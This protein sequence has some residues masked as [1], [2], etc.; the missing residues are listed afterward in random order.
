MRTSHRIVEHL[1]K[2][3]I[4]YFDGCPNHQPT[5]DLVRDVVAA[6]ELDA[7]IVETEVTSP[8]DAGRLRFLGSPSVRVDGVD[9]EPDARQRRDF[10][11]SCRTYG[12][13]GMPD[14]EMLTRALREAQAGDV[15]DGQAPGQRAGLL[16]A[17]GAV[18]SALASSACC[19]VPLVLIGFGVS[20]GG[21]SG[22]MEKYRLLF[23]G[24]AAVMLATGFYFV[25][26]RATVCAAGCGCAA[27]RSRLRQFNRVMIW[28]ATALVIATA[29]FPKTIGYL[30]GDTATAET[31]VPASGVITVTFAVE[32]MTCDGCAVVLRTSLVKVPGV[33]DARVSYPDRQAVIS[34]DSA[35]LSGNELLVAAIRSAGYDVAGDADDQP[36]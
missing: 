7:E 36:E 30:L 6:A 4:L 16:A 3:E 22:W 5:V 9:V 11:L 34:I 27:P 14:R 13:R 17:G 24:A 32:G 20:A 8:D 31:A 26:F 15:P 33:L 18:A 19:W 35:V 10:G 12:G 29:T 28:V 21:I 25:Y 23:L 1:M 2:V